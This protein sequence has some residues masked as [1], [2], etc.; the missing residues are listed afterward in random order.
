[1]TSDSPKPATAEQNDPNRP[2]LKFRITNL[3]CGEG[4]LRRT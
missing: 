2:R 3:M 4:K 1:M